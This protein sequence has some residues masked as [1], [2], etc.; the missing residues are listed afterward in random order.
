MAL[1]MMKSPLERPSQAAAGGARMYPGTRCGYC[2]LEM[3]D[4][5]TIVCGFIVHS[6]GCAHQVE[7]RE[8]A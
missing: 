4:G 8:R 7:V 3:G 5:G 6:E 2:G 1:A